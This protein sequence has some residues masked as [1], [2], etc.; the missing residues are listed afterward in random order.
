MQLN[1]FRMQNGGENALTDQQTEQLLAIMKDEKQAVA[2]QTGQT[3]PDAGQSDAA[4][5]EAMLSGDSVEKLL[6]AQETVNQ[7]VY[8]RAQDVLTESQ[9]NSFARFQTNQLQMMRVGMA[10]ARK[11]MVPEAPSGST[12]SNP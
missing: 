9:L 8:E 11:F 6:Q 4:K 7:R 5:F 12:Q 2:K 3:F 10:M 1:Q